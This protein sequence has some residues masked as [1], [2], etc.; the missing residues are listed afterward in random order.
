[1]N[2]LFGGKFAPITNTIGFLRCDHSRAAQAFFDWQENIQ[3]K[4]GVSL[5]K[6]SIHGGLESAIQKLL[7]LTSVER[8]R[9][10]LISTRSDWTAFLDNGHQGTDVFSPLSYL[11]EKL[12]CE[13]V[14]ATY[15]P[16]GRGKQ[17]PAVIF[18]LYGPNRSEF[19]NYVRSIAVA[20]D[21]KKWAFA[22]E[23]EVQPF[24]QVERYSTRS[25]QD[26]FTPEM[27][28]NYLKSLGIHAFRQD[29]YSPDGQEAILI[30]KVGPIAPAA[31]EFQL[32]DVQLA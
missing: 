16:E 1:M 17:Y 7:P 32:A 28:E 18:E 19:L 25:I 21:G 10:L 2:D 13:A 27:L 30:E 3:A 11:A 9:Y 20:Y 22:A 26:R 6:R 15:V 14:R 24:E 4:R 29:F 31:R 5:V 23:G 8:R 12:S